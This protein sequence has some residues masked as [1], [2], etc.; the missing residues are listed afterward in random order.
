M[1]EKHKDYDNAVLFLKDKTICF[2][3]ELMTHFN[4]GYNSAGMLVD[5]L[6]DNKIIGQFE[7]SK[8]RK[9]LINR[10]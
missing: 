5:Q 4:L 3:A 7:G 9:V 2:C 8:G 10:Q 1:K 6:E